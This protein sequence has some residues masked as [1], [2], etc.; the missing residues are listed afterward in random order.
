MY[1]RFSQSKSAFRVLCRCAVKYHWDLKHCSQP[2]VQRT[3][4][5]IATLINTAIE[6]LISDYSMLFLWSWTLVPSVKWQLNN[7]RS[8]SMLAPSVCLYVCQSGCCLCKNGIQSETDVT[9]L[10]TFVVDLRRHRTQTQTCAVR[11]SSN[12]D[13]HSFIHS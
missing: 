5:T 6:L 7:Y 12:T 9:V 8:T 11:V 10:Y 4:V 3:C 13:F 2:A 1:A